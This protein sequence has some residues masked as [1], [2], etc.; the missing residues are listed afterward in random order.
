MG[1]QRISR[2]HYLALSALVAMISAIQAALIWLR[3]TPSASVTGMAVL[4]PFLASLGLVGASGIVAVIVAGLGLRVFLPGQPNLQ[5]WLAVAATIS[6]AFVSLR[7]FALAVETHRSTAESLPYGDWNHVTDPAIRP[8]RIWMIA[9]GAAVCAGT[10]VLVASLNGDREGWYGTID[11][12]ARYFVAS[13]IVVV[14]GVLMVRA[15]RSG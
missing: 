14:G 15:V 12:L 1:K 11:R 10:I 2:R 7:L 6:A 13:A 9:A 4:W 3:E 8:R 5:W